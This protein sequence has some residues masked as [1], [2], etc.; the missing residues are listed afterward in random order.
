MFAEK[1]YG[2]CPYCTLPLQLLL[3]ARHCAGRTMAV[4]LRVGFEHGGIAHSTVGAFDGD[5]SVGDLLRELATAQ[6]LT[7]FLD[8]VAEVR[9]FPLSGRLRSVFVRPVRRNKHVRRKT[10]TRESA[11]GSRSDM[12]QQTTNQIRMP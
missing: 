6:K 9:N 10:F 3:P 11:P 8:R 7:V 1:H 4:P 2:S 12:L 5:M